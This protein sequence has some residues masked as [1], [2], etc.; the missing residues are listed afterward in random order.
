MFHKSRNI[1]KYKYRPPCFSFVYL[2]LIKYDSIS[3][4]DDKHCSL[5]IYA[6]ISFLYLGESKLI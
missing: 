5:N 3:I 6:Y 4:V 1:W 2:I